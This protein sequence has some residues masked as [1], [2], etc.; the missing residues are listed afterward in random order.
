MYSVHFLKIYYFPSGR[1]I[2]TTILYN[3]SKV[4]PLTPPLTFCNQFMELS[5]QTINVHA[6]ASD[7]QLLLCWFIIRWNG[8]P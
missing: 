7:A 2:L 6:T 3:F 5:K 4:F 1:E 8:F